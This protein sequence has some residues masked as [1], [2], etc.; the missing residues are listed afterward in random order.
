ML[1]QTATGNKRVSSGK[2]AIDSINRRAFVKTRDR[3]GYTQVLEFYDQVGQVEEY[4]NISKWFNFT[5]ESDK[6]LL[7]IV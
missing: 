5:L 6:N 4:S 7:Q 1:D 2:F 3:T